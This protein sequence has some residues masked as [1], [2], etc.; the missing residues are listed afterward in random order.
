MSVS[1]RHQKVCIKEEKWAW[2]LREPASSDIDGWNAWS[3]LPD[4]AVE[5]RFIESH[6]GSQEFS[7]ANA[8]SA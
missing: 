2:T 5:P 4:A 1:A 3:P 6:G 8:C 7:A